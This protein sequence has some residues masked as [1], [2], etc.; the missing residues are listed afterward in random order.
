MCG[1]FLGL[2]Q[3]GQISNCTYYSGGMRPFFPWIAIS[4]MSSGSTTTILWCS[5]WRYK[6]LNKSWSNCVTQNQWG[7]SLFEVFFAFQ[8]NPLLCFLQKNNGFPCCQKRVVPSTESLGSGRSLL[9]YIYR[10]NKG[11][12]LGI[13]KTASVLDTKCRESLVAISDQMW[14]IDGLTKFLIS[15]AS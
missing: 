9:A 4:A 14:R 11:E 5:T 10:K 3:I 6:K 13:W 15:G 1:I 2:R 8:K 7:G 12:N